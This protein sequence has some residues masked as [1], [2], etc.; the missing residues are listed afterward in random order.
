MHPNT[1]TMLERLPRYRKFGPFL[2]RVFGERVYRIGLCGG[3]GCP[4]RDGRLG[5]GG[6][7]FC[8]P[9]SSEPLGHRPGRSISEQLTRGADYIRRRHGAAKFI[10]FFEELTSTYGDVHTLESMYRQAVAHPDVVGLTLSTRPDCLPP[11]VLRLLQR[12]SR[13]NRLW[14]E[15]GVQSV[16]DAT[17]QR[18]NR[19]HTAEDSRNA[20]A[21]VR[22]LGIPVT[23]HVI[24]GLPGEGPKD[25]EATA[26]FL[27]EAGVNGA[28][29]HNLHIV[30][31]T[32]LAAL[33]AQ[34]EFNPPSLET[35]V[36]MVCAF[37]ENLSPDVIIQRLTGE[38]PRRLTVA[39]QW[40][41]N[42]WTALNAIDSGLARRDAWQG[43]RL[44]TERGD[45]VRP[46]DLPGWLPGE[47][48]PIVR[49][50]SRSRA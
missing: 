22:L 41:V 28:K 24:L 12:F 34:G 36:G 46:V 6:C 4:N 29:I 44:G 3:F 9:E 50:H 45:L 2:K 18:I 17:L 5:T 48:L 25:V 7:V 43:K 1:R 49:P 16:R 33:H 8:N 37:L 42:K 26:R 47:S 30:E 13:E 14:V 32:K 31:K 23:A 20:I 40:S 10:A 15:L 38:A 11:E 35:Y 27:T 19:C 39:P 21:A